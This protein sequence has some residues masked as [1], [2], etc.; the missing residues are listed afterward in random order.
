MSEMRV[1]WP[2]SEAAMQETVRALRV[3]EVHLNQL[4]MDTEHDQ[5]V[6]TRLHKQVVKAMD[7]LA[8]PTVAVTS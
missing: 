5:S 7:A 6:V 2:P 3:V 8:V 4:V 1:A